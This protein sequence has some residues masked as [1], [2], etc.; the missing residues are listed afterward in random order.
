MSPTTAARSSTGASATA[1]TSPWSRVSAA[2]ATSRAG[3]PKVSARTCPGHCGQSTTTAS[4]T[5]HA[6]SAG[7]CASRNTTTAAKTRTTATTNSAAT[8]AASALCG[9]NHL[10][11]FIWILQKVFELVALRSKNSRSQLRRDFRAGY[12]RI[13]GDIANLVDLDGGV[14]SEGGLQLFSK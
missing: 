4:R 7:S 12:G 11:Q 6:A 14:S 3:L 1:R 10:Q 9:K 8:A 2:R 13:F 5:A